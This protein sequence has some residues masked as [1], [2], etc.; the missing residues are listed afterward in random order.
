MQKIS[1]E[2]KRTDLDIGTLVVGNARVGGTLKKE[3]LVVR[4]HI[5]ENKLT[6]IDTDGT[7][8]DLNVG[9]YEIGE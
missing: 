1:M 7:V 8:E 2:K 3:A 5:R 9:H 6:Q 4:P